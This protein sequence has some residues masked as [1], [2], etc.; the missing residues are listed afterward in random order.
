M[1]K[2]SMEQV[3]QDEF[4]RFEAKLAEMMESKLNEKFD[5]MIYE[6]QVCKYEMQDLKTSVNFLNEMFEEMKKENKEMKEEMQ[7]IKR[8]NE[9]F[10][11]EIELAK[12]TSVN[13][14]IKVNEMDNYLRLNNVEL[15]GI[16]GASNE[17]VDRIAL[18]VLKI[19]EP[20]LVE[21]DIEMVKRLKSIN[22][23]DGSLR[24]TNPILVKFKSR[25]KR[26]AVISN[27]RKLAGVDFRRINL[28][29][30]S[31]FINDNLSSFSKA[32]FYKANLLK[33]E[34]NWKYLWTSNG[35]ILL[36][37]HESAQ[38]VMIRDESDLE[39]LLQ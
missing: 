28:N 8:E 17:N 12:A 3:L 7:S 2:P 38:A 14:T 37:K 4:V 36:K 10:K 20:S 32:L 9:A 31:V 29:T 33:K 21:G 11:K 25:E 24:A 34:K 19:V 1:S 23:K 22:N 27:R 13:A 6:M 30:S 39:K 5:K 16:P 18:G 35:N 26:V 15:H